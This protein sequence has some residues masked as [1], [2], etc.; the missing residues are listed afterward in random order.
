MSNPIN[1]TITRPKQNAAVVIGRIL[2]GVVGLLVAAL[3]VWLITPHFWSDYPLSYWQT[4]GAT[5]VVRILTSAGST[6]YLYW[7]RGWSEPNG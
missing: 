1:V 6:N 2:G 5:Y 7:S 3:L 4:L